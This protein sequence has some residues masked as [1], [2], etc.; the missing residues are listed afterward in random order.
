MTD[1]TQAEIERLRAEKT[2][3]D[4]V[5]ALQVYIEWVGALHDENCPEDD[6]C[7]CSCKPVNDGINAAVRYLEAKALADASLLRLREYVQ[8]K[9]DC[10]LFKH[11]AC[12]GQ[13][14][15]TFRREEAT[16]GCVEDAGHAGPHK[17]YGGYLEWV[18][19]IC[20][21]GLTALTS[22]LSIPKTE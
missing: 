2:P 1:A 4:M 14:P 16:Y 12:N 19:E 13:C 10:L 22:A 11:T 15:A 18:E 8:H 9:K 3:A 20:T 7:D 5:K 6:T 21:C 17:S